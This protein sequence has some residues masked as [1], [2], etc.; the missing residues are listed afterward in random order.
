MG[1]YARRPWRLV[2]Q[3]AFD[4][5]VLVWAIVWWLASRLV[6]EAIRAV[7]GPVGQAGQAASSMRDHFRAAAKQVGAVPAIGE[8]LRRPFDDA[9]DS[10]GGLIASAGAQVASIER[11]ASIVG[12]LVFLIPVAIMVAI[13]LPKRIRFFVRARAT[14]RFIGSQTDLDLFALRAMATQPIQV[15]ARI[16]SDPVSD[17]RRGDSRVINRLAEVE[18]KR[19]GLRPPPRAVLQPP[20]GQLG[21]H[22]DQ[23]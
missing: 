2:G 10:L 3:L 12:W 6:D 8:Q 17:W 23:A 19:V 4:I 15:L 9:A 16:S 22:H 7:A 18:L 1:F 21:G 20:T 13:W 14:Q 5:S 11:L